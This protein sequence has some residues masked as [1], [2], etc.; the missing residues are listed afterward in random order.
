MTNGYGGGVY[1]TTN[2]M[3]FNGTEVAIKN[4]KAHLPCPLPAV[5]PWYRQY[6][7]YVASGTPTT[8]NGFNPATQVTAN[9][10]I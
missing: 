1:S 9:T 2:T 10:H 5:A 6:G 3:T 8:K 4:N 7:V